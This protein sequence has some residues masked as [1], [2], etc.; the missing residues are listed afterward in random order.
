[1]T[2]TKVISF[3]ALV[4][5]L[6]AS[7]AAS[8]GF[9]ARFQQTNELRRANAAVWRAVLCD[10]E[11]RIIADGTIPHKRKVKYIKYYDH[12]LVDHIRTEPCGVPY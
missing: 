3:I 1:M 4:C 10:I 2:S 5:I 9:Y 6:A 12:L 11:K 8:V 7:V